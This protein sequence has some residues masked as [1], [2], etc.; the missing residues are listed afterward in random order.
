MDVV[1]SATGLYRDHFPNVIKQLARAVQLAA[2]AT[3]EHDN[4]VARN[5]QRIEVALRKRGMDEK[6]GSTT[7]RK[8]I[9]SSESGRYGTGLDDATL[10][11]DTWKGKAEG[12]RKLAQLY[13]DRMQFAYGRE[14]R[15]RW[16]A[17]VGDG[18]A[19]PLNLYAELFFV[20]KKR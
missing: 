1:L 6:T 15:A 10:A 4:P 17:R 16:G 12:D 5:S 20:A 8:R 2:D 9:F 14:L 19:A 7:P 11:T 3:D 18:T 13:L